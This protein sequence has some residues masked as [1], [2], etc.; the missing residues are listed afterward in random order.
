[1]KT[2]LIAALIV[3]FSISVH[4][5][6]IFS[7]I[8][9]KEIQVTRINIDAESALL[10]AAEVGEVE[11]VIGDVI[12]IE[13]AI[14]TKIGKASITIQHGNTKTIIPVVYGFE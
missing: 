7:D 13:G 6:E 9:V 2:L 3:M 4:A 14:V 1:M 8:E 5:E 12:G 10:R 11:V